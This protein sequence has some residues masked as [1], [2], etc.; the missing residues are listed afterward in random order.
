MARVSDGGFRA[1]IKDAGLWELVQMRCE[2]RSRCVIRVS[3]KGQV[4]YLYFAD[5]QIVH[6]S[7]GDNQGESAALTILSWSEGSF[8]PCDRSW[9]ARASIN[10]VWQGL[11]LRAAQLRDETSRD[12]GEIP[13]DDSA[14]VPVVASATRSVAQSA[15]TTPPPLPDAK[16]TDVTD[17]TEVDEVLEPG[18]TDHATDQQAHPHNVSYRADDFEHAVRLDAQGEVLTGHGDTEALAGLAAYAV[19]LGDLIGE[20]MGMDKLAAIEGGLR[21]GKRCLIFRDERGDIVALRP[22]VHVDLTPLK[23]RLRL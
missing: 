3:S 19:R 23:T 8:D 22:A 18:A 12:S 16:T 7:L 20:I 21:S 14:V 5:G 11:L 9:P 17:L 6:A 13:I 4:G 2:A 1:M 15:F 10:V